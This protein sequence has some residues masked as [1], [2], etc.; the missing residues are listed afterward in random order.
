MRAHALVI[1]EYL[2]SC[3]HRHAVEHPTETDFYLSPDAELSINKETVLVHPTL[4]ETTTED[5]RK[6]VDNS[7]RAAWYNFSA[8]APPSASSSTMAINTALM[9][10]LFDF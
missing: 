6:L 1:V 8:A 10:R 4:K 5:Q 3:H 9:F 7:K 2:I